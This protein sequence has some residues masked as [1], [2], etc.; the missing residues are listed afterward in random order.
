MEAAVSDARTI[1]LTT[2]P[3][4]K[5]LKTNIHISSDEEDPDEYPFPLTLRNK[6]PGGDASPVPPAALNGE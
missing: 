5:M 6:A 3:F 2:I 1:I 4:F